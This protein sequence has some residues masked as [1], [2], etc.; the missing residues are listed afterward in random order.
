MTWSRQLKNIPGIATSRNTTLACRLIGLSTGAALW[1]AA[2]NQLTAL[3]DTMLFVARLSRKTRF[4]EA[5]H[6]S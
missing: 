2:W 3:A 5:L 6:C 1:L 4:G